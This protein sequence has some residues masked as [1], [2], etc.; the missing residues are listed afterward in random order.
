LIIEGIESQNPLLAGL[1]ERVLV[2][3]DQQ[4]ADRLPGKPDSIKDGVYVPEKPSNDLSVNSVPVP[5]PYYPVA[6]INTHA[7]TREL[8]RVLNAS[9]DTYLDLQLK[10]GRTPE[11]VGVV[12]LDGVSINHENRRQPVLWEDHIPLPPGARAEFIFDAPAEGVDLRLVTLGVQTGPL[13]DDDLSGPD[14]SVPDDDDHMPPRPLAKIVISANS[15]PLPLLPSSPTATEHA[16]LTPLSHTRPNR[17]RRL[18]FSEAPVDS[19]KP[20]GPKVFFITEVGH[21]AKAFDPAVTTPDITVKQG[22]V[23][24]WIIENRSQESHVFHIHQ[25]HFIALERNGEAIDEPYLRDTITVHYWDGYSPE[26]PSVKLRIDFR[27]REIVGTFP[28][29]CHVLLHEDGGMMGTIRVLP[30]KRN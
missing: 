24:D 23:E 17:V 27:G 30:A 10:A 14:G 15:S 11:R 2:V 3:R 18:Y 22:E 4:N 26:F 21:P 28:Y 13:A 9:A 8:W 12:A 16:G 29:H 25:T 1:P 7:A 6:I 19:K 5:Y 20:A